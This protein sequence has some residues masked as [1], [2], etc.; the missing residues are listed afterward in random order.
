MVK[1]KNKHKKKKR[2]K[3]PVPRGCAQNSNA[4]K[5]RKVNKEFTAISHAGDA[6]YASKDA[7]TKKFA[8]RKQITVVWVVFFEPWEIIRLAGDWRIRE[9]TMSSVSC[10]RSA[11]LDF[12][13]FKIL[14]GPEIWRFDVSVILTQWGSLFVLTSTKQLSN[15][16]MVTDADINAEISRQKSWTSLCV[17]CLPYLLLSLSLSHTHAHGYLASWLCPVGGMVVVVVVVAIICILK[18]AELPSVDWSALAA[19]RAHNMTHIQ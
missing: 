16:G 7:R 3:R 19:H 10:N 17:L 15:E 14:G 4:R 13:R 11:W 5:E 18:H 1:S 2:K 9:S 12:N 8:A 6:V